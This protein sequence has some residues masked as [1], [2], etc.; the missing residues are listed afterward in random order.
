MNILGCLDTPTGGGYRFARCGGGRPGTQSART[1]R[2]DY[3]GFVFQGY[4]LFHRTSALEN[5]ELP[6]SIAGW[7]RAS[8]ENWRARRWP[9]SV[10]GAGNRTLRRTLGRT[11]AAR[12]DRPG[13]R[14][15]TVGAVCGRA[16]RES[17]YSPAAS[18]LWNLLVRLQPRA[19]H[20]GPMVTHEPDMAAYAARTIRF[21]DGHVESD[22]RN[23][24]SHYALQRRGPGVS[25]NPTQRPAL[26][27]TALGIIIGVASVIIMV[28]LGNGATRRSSRHRQ[29]GQQ[30]AEVMPGRAWPRRRI[31]KREA[32]QASGWEALPATSRAHLRRPGLIHQPQRHKRRKELVDDVTGTTNVYSS[33]Q[34]DSW[35]AGAFPES[36]CAPARRLHR[37]RHHA[38]GT[39]RRARPA[40]DWLRLRSPLVQGDRRAAVEGQEQLGS[41]PRRYRRDSDSYFAAPPYRQR[42][43]S[44]GA[45]VGPQS[46]S[47]ERAQQDIIG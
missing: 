45:V 12:G 32:V 14:H 19:R 20:H 18:R 33:G 21:R 39:A 23:G 44:P 40:R 15:R 4:N 25:R 2:R 7:L 24:R 41:G 37:G 27:A 9:P 47:S 10:S 17:G 34:L 38:Q 5:V 36:G 46:A 43:H 11:E 31:W 35:R 30:P 6:S 26:V 16:D 8:G 1:V 22:E 29:H 13:H 3:L 42:G 28:T